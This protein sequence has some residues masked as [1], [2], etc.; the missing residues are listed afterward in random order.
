MDVFSISL[1]QRELFPATTFRPLLQLLPMM[2]SEIRKCYFKAGSKMNRKLIQ[3]STDAI[4]E[5][6]A[7]VIYSAVILH[8][9]LNAKFSLIYRYTVVKKKYSDPYTVYACTYIA[10]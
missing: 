9:W 1:E 5:N 8:E 7:Q 4:R 10:I 6:P 3:S 2:V